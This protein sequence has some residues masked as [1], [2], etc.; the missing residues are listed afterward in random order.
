MKN[1]I[2]RLLAIV[3]ALLCLFAILEP[4]AR[5][6]DPNL[7]LQ[8]G[9]KNPF[10]AHHPTRGHALKPG[11]FNSIWGVPFHINQLGFRGKEITQAKPANT[12][13]VFAI[14]DSITFGSGLPEN[15]IYSDLLQQL[16]EHRYP[17]KRFEVI[18]GGV[19][20][21]DIPQELLLLKEDGL[22][23]APDLVVLQ[24]CL[25]DVPGVV[26]ADLINPRRDLPIPGKKF[27]LAHLAAARFMQERYNRIGLRNNFLGLADLIA[28]RPGSPEAQ[29][30]QNGWN[31]YFVRLDEM[32][33]LCRKNNVAF[34]ILIVPHE[35]QFEDRKKEFLP[36]H[37]IME[38]ARQKK[39]DVIDLEPAFAKQKALP[40]IMGDPVHPDRSGHEIIARLLADWTAQSI[41]PGKPL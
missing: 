35:A 4:V 8:E 13:R 40:Y 33:D 7:R 26:F 17:Q 36:Q 3:F 34:L 10:W 28:M 12:F 32:V 41:F 20:G 18:N 29:R 11:D 15:V 9:K 2:F 39:I 30:I 37:K 23:L 27:L 19:S 21:Y 1:W 22:A 25:N 14:G 6:F 5:Y 16:L 31:D 24:F 38:H